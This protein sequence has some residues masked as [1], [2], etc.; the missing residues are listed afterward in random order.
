LDALLDKR[1]VAPDSGRQVGDG[2]C[3]G[4]GVGD[5]WH[6]RSGGADGSNHGFGLIEIVLRED[7]I[8]QV[9]LER[10]RFGDRFSEEATVAGG[11][12]VGGILSVW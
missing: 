5:R 4:S 8:D 6:H 12:E 3:S 11:E 2:L 1:F 10:N 7:L 9:M